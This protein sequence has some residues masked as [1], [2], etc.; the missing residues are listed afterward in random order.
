MARNPL[1]MNINGQLKKEKEKRSMTESSTR[2]EKTQVR[3]LNHILQVLN[4]VIVKNPN[5][6]F[7]VAFA[8]ETTMKTDAQIDSAAT[9]NTRNLI[10]SAPDSPKKPTKV[11]RTK[12]PTTEEGKKKET[13][14]I[15]IIAIKIIVIITISKAIRN[16][17]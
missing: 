16:S 3:I 4:R 17:I 10:R 1:K 9:K 12:T 6:R 11:I 5:Q 8:Q 2:I 15:A 14:N 13:E 7:S